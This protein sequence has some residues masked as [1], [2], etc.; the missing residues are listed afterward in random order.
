MKILVTERQLKL[1]NEETNG[2]DEFMTELVSHHNKVG[3]FYDIVVDFIKDSGCQNIELK[4]I[5]IGAL[6]LALHNKV[7]INPVV[8]D[9]QLNRCL[10]VIFHE[11]AHQYQYKKY[12]KKKM[13]ELYTGE[14]SL[15]KAVTFL[16]H[17]ENV[18]DQFSIRKCREL[19]KLGLLDKKSL[20]TRG[21]YENM[22]DMQLASTLVKFRNLLRNNKVTDSERVSEVM[23]NSIINGINGEPEKSLTEENED[24]IKCK[25]CDWKWKKSDGGKNPYVC[26]QCGHNNSPNSKF[27][28]PEWVRCKN[29]KKRFTQTIMKNGKKSLPICPTCGTHH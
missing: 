17:T 9:M 11:I 15:E 18:A 1:L 21:N 12:G 6:G 24:I 16:K 3:E 13:Y 8:L 28:Q 29:C 19:Q 26:H 20:I 5:H 4:P 2:L 7:V 22:G 25:Q 10:Y 14:L 27:G 23:Y